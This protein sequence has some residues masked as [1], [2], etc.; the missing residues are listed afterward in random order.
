MKLGG[1][2]SILKPVP[3][4]YGIVHVD[5]VYGANSVIVAEYWHADGFLKPS[6]MVRK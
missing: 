4:E 5:L 6:D 3:S 2:Q 1:I